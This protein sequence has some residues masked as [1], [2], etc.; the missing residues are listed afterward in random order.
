MKKNILVAQSGGPTAV[1]NSSLAGVIRGGI[2]NSDSVGEIF[3]AVNGIE[4]VENDTLVSL[5]RFKDP[6]ELS[7]LRQTPSSYLGSCRRKLPDLAEDEETYSR[8]MS[9][10]KKHNIGYFFYIGG[11]DS[12]DTADKLSRYAAELNKDIRIVGIPKT[13][14]NDLAVTDHTPGY[15]SAAKFVANTL[16]QLTLDT[17]VYKMKSVIILEI[18]GRNAGWLTAAAALANDSELSAADIICLPEVAF[19]P[20]RLLAE[21]E[22]VSKAQKT[23]ML[24]V[25][26]GIKDRHGNYIAENSLA[27][28]GRDDKF[29]HAALGG[30]GKCVE[31]M[32]SD[33]LGL[34]T[35]TIELS[36][37]QRCWAIGASLRDENEAF[38]AGRH[39]VKFAV[40]DG[41]TCIMP[42]FKRLSDDPYR[43]EIVPIDVNLTAN[44]EKKVPANM[45]SENGFGVTE[46]FIRYTAPLIEGE[47]TVSYQNGIVRFAQLK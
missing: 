28:Q 11:N 29:A 2:E 1:I 46:D 47:P 13:I 32:I 26:E 23:V 42:S 39:G 22:R 3:G 43:M 25:S 24:A 4:G 45:I 41:L 12:M 8:I 7:L 44:H 36:T 14:D 27:A 9:V 17:G 6:F 21:V 40:R 31:S 19:D 30:V 20:D 5:E 37:L 18:M 10:L 16:R 35:R 33:S 15:G 34:K 38:E